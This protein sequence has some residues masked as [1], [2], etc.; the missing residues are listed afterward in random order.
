MP[1]TPTYPG[2]YIEEI[3]SGV[4]TITGVSTSIAAFVGYAPR[5]PLNQ[6][7]R[8]FNFGDYER[9]FGG[10]HRDSDIS[11]SI[12]QFFLNGGTDAYVVRV[13]SGGSVAQTIL[14]SGDTDVLQ[15]EA[16]NAGSWG[17]E[18]VI[19]VDHGPDVMP[20]TSTFNLEIKRQSDSK[21]VE[22]ERYLN[23]SLNDQSS[24]YAVDVLNTS[25][26]VQAQL[27]AGLTFN[28]AGYSQSKDLS[29]IDFSTEFSG[30]RKGVIALSVD[31]GDSVDLTIFDTQADPPVTAP[32]DIN[33]LVAAVT[34]AIT[35]KA[36]LNNAVTASEDANTLKLTSSTPGKNS[37]VKVSSA[38]ADDIAEILM[39]GVA[40]GG[41][42]GEGAG[43]HRPDKEESALTGG[44]DGGPPSSANNLLGSY[45]SK[46]GLYALRDV[47]LFNLLIIPRTAKLVDASANAVIAKA[48]KFCNDE[49][50]FY[51][52]DP[53]SEKTFETI[54][55]WAPTATTDKNA[56]VFFPR[57]KVADPLKEFRLRDMPVAGAIAGIFARTDS[58]RGVWKA[59]AGTEAA[60]RG[61]QGLTYTLTDPEN[62]VLNPMGINCLRTFPVYGTIL[63]GARTRAGA[64]QLA[65]EWKYIPVRRLAL[66]LEESLFR[67]TQWVVFEP[68]DEPLWAQIR[69]NIG[70][71]M[72]NLF[73][74]GAFQGSSPKEAYFVK[75]DNETTTQND[76]NLGIVNIIVGYAPLKP[77]EFVI[78]KF[79]QI[80]GSIET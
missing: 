33:T 2:V 26:L 4:R 18:L 71:F 42:E 9:T 30:K 38:Q 13:A 55:S 43:Q 56:A 69:L 34:S 24:R 80:A 36:A 73:R 74:Q 47:D 49:R 61:A 66:F 16:S 79:Q 65:S 10:L 5:G 3:P 46:T 70:A 20:L 57:M 44:V 19:E 6:A 48:V 17:N 76:I 78:L 1:V 64:D 7:V 50:A 63:W 77:A 52:I 12:Q 41:T 29:N 25:S 51:L 27:V 45:E 32:T 58:G 14:K 54:R 37:S 62:G 40:N 59:P 60:V 67:G 22:T 53:P 75:C 23:L 8:I 21:T 11:Y 68:N 72:N 39:L 15:I 31:G 28:Q 35:A